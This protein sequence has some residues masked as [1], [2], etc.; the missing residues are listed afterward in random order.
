[1][2][3]FVED[4]EKDNYLKKIFEETSPKEDS[5]DSLSDIPTEMMEKLK[6]KFEMGNPQEV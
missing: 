4:K 6:I 3:M 2:A 1:M 5:F